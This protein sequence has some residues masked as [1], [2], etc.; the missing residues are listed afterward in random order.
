MNYGNTSVT[1]YQGGSVGA[2]YPSPY[3]GVWHMS[4]GTTLSLLDS[5]ANG[6]NGT[7]SSVTAQAGMLDGGIGLASASSASVD[8]G[9]NITNYSISMD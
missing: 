4:D 9:N 7:G 5:T 8:L 3:K 2:A 1:T 6:N